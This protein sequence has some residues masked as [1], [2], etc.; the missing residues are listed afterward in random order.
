MKQLLG[1]FLLS[2][3]VTACFTFSLYN[4]DI[5]SVKYFLSYLF[6]IMLTLVLSK[7]IKNKVWLSSVVLL[8]LIAID[9]STLINGKSLIPLRFPFATIF[10]V[11]GILTGFVI[12]QGKKFLITLT[13]LGSILFTVLSHK[14]FIPEIMWWMLNRD[15]PKISSSIFSNNFK[16]INESLIQFKD[17]FKAELQLVEFYFVK[18]PPCESK[19]ETLKKVREKYSMSDLDIIM[20]CDGN[21]SA[22]P[23]F[24]THQEKK[25]LSGITFLYDN[26][27]NIERNINSAIGYPTELLIKNNVIRHSQTGF[28]D[29]SASQYYKSETERIN[30]LLKDE[31]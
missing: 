26:A 14:Y 20:V 5:L 12:L 31:E 10:P 30:K 8:P 22:Y 23:E 6:Y 9:L 1:P 17:T 24:I 21:I 25:K 3:V 4:S 18:C 16:T 19:Y 11:L 28:N 7:F 29:E 13:I 15:K 2:L 27:K